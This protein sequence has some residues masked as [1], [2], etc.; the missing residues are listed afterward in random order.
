MRF[1]DIDL[2]GT[3]AR[4]RLNDK[5]P[6][7]SEAI[8]NAL[9]FKGQA[10]HAQISG[11]MF[12][13]LDTT[14]VGE[15]EL[16]SKITHQWPGAIVYYPPIK[17]IAFCAG[18]ARFSGGVFASTLT[19]LGE[20]EG[21]FGEFMKKGDS[22]DRTGAKPIEF[23][24]S[25]DQTTAFRAPT[26]PPRKGKRLSIDFDGVKVGATLL[27]NMAP[28]TV[29]A[30]AALLPLECDATND[31][32]GAQ[33]TRLWGPGAN[34]SFKIDV[35]EP[36]SPKYLAWPGFVY[37]DAAKRTLRVSYGEA[38]LK[39]IA[40]QIAATPVA[41]IDPLDVEKYAKKAFA[42]LTEGKKRIRLQLA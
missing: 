10:V 7:T 15:L 35:S 8:W 27:E 38:D 42:Q 26:Y 3:V 32:W 12:R 17:E 1:I 41:A 28:K 33:I 5:A 24:R 16:E 19:L 34:G 14:P 13:M 37:F 20:I 18:E 39:D 11:E 2:D 4:A 22:L 30:L 21:D 23:R 40:G 25:A 29:A 9:P 36:E 31:T 6:K